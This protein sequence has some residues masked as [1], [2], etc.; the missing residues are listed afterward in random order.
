MKKLL[1]TVN[2]KPYRPLITAL[3]A[4]KAKSNEEICALI[5]PKNDRL[6][7]PL[8]FTP[9]AMRTGTLSSLTNSSNCLENF[10]PALGHESHKL[11][12]TDVPGLV[13]HFINTQHVDAAFCLEPNK[14]FI[15]LK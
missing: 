12:Y 5:N 1:K 15:D 13:D 14:S 3:L 8:T 7:P 9:T 4:N 10:L 2:F 6:P 11:M